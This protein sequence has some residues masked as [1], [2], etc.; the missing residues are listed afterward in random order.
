[1]FPRDTPVWRNGREL[2]VL[3]SLLQTTVG[4]Q[5]RQLLFSLWG[6]TAGWQEFTQA[7]PHNLTGVVHMENN[8]FNVDNGLSELVAAGAAK[9]HTIYV[10][11]DPYREWDGG[12]SRMMAIPGQSWQGQLSACKALRVQGA[13]AFANWAPGW[14]WPNHN[15]HG[16]LHNCSANCSAAGVA[17]AG[18]WQDMRSVPS[19]PGY[20]SATAFTGQ[21]AA[22]VLLA[23]LLWNASS[24]PAALLA[25][26]A[27][28][29][30]LA[31]NRSWA[32]RVANAAAVL[33]SAW[34][35]LSRN[36]GFESKW[37]AVFNPNSQG[38]FN[39]RLSTWPTIQAYI[40]STYQQTESALNLVQGV[41]GEFVG[42]PI[43]QEARRLLARSVNVTAEFLR[44]YAAFKAANWLNSELAQSGSNRT[45][46]C[47][48][49][50]EAL[51]NMTT[52]IQR[53][54]AYPRESQAFQ[55]AALDP[56]LYTRPIFFRADNNR[57]MALYHDGVLL[58][59]FQQLCAA[60]P[61]SLAA[62]SAGGSIPP[63]GRQ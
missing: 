8:G 15:T 5:G 47:R 12:W 39:P 40:A 18:R 51:A 53:W 1:V 49:Q 17:W 2:G 60:A 46:T 13:V 44:V 9:N 63:A 28:Q 11:L 32:L 57:S 16:F 41:T 62:S 7:A 20:P 35:L 29:W 61:R 59:R 50:A 22:A 45:T 52:L 43:S 23:R 34:A 14:S 24:D 30:P 58:P 4:M 27:G 26:W 21:E 25:D 55:I 6:G 10:A 48:L 56:S 42:D 33:E 31:L 37:M 36:I 3:A 38:A 19:F 54:H